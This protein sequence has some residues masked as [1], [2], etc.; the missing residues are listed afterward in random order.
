M[1]GIPVPKFFRLTFRPVLWRVSHGKYTCLCVR[2]DGRAL[3]GSMLL[4]VT[5]YL[6]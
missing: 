5:A 6:P 2:C 3:N 1:V 4:L